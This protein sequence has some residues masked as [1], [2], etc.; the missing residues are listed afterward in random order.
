[1]TNKHM[2][3]CSTSCVIR[4]IHIKTTMR[5]YY[6]PIRMAKTLN[7]DNSKCWWGCGAKGT[8]NH[9]WWECKMAQSLW[10]TLWLEVESI[11]N[12]QWVNQSCLC[13]EASI[14]TQKDRVQ[15][16]SRLVNMWRLGRVAYWRERGN[17]FPF[18]MPCP[19]Q[20]FIW[21][22]ICIL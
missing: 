10:K 19:M 7:T 6:I 5:Y 2:K 22:L 16:A 15:R 17:S 12:G 14:K 3:R 21:L 20:L 1:M 11:T 8:L 9:C 4:E 13:N 18:P